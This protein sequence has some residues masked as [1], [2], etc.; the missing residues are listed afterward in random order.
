[1][2]NLFTY[3]NMD[4]LPC[5]YLCW[6]NYKGSVDIFR[7]ILERCYYDENIYVELL[8]SYNGDNIIF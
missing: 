3:C 2:L 8:I 4:N 1:M 6:S 5:I 7:F